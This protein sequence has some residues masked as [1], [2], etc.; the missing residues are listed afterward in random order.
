MAIIA[1]DGKLV[2]ASAGGCTW[3]RVF[4]EMS[5]DDQEQYE[6]AWKQRFGL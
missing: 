2:H 4:F 3:A 1:K 6:Q 5:D